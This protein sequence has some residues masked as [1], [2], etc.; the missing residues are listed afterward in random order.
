M[1]KTIAPVMAALLLGGASMARG[2]CVN[3]EAAAKEIPFEEEILEDTRLGV[4]YLSIIGG[5]DTKAANDCGLNASNAPGEWMGWGGPL[6]TDNASIGEG[7][8]TRNFLTIGGIRFERGIGTHALAT[9]V[10]DISGENYKKF[11]A[12]VG[13]D[14]EKDAGAAGAGDSCGFGG[15]CE[16]I[17]SVD[18]SVEFESGFVSGM[19][20]GDNVEAIFVEI[21]LASASEIMIEIADAGD[22]IGCDHASIGDAKVLTG[23]ALAVDAASKAATTWAAMKTRL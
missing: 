20:G 1:Y 12:Y 14:D 13:M 9:Y 7:I 6:D 5:S 21:D 19:D 2:E 18:G 3:L 4:T 11:E 22:G 16:F 15:T 10:F 8:G 17:I 23:A